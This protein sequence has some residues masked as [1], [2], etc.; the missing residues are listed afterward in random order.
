MDHETL[1]ARYKFFPYFDAVT[2]GKAYAAADLMLSRS[3]A[4]TIFEAAATGTAAILVPLPEA[5][6]N[7]QFQNAYTY[8]MRGAALFIEEDNFLIGVFLNQADLLLKNPEKLKAMQ[9]AARAFYIDG[10]AEMIAKDIL[11]LV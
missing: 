9:D 7:H 1:A 8:H 5:A 10:G 6:Q 2:M 3:G 11:S 4:S